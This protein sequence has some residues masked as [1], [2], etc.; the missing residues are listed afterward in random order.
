MEKTKLDELLM[1][2]TKTDNEKITIDE[3]Q[4]VLLKFANKYCLMYIDEAKA[5]I[6]SLLETLDE[7]NNFKVKSRQLFQPPRL[8][9]HPSVIPPV[10]V[11]V[12]K[13]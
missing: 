5:E 1:Q 7:E 12:S 6:S 2:F 13:Y 9:V 8:S 4:N 11:H 3:I 10:H